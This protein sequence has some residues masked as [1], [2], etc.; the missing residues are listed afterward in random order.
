MQLGSNPKRKQCNSCPI[1]QK[2]H[3]LLPILPRLALPFT[4]D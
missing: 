3:R 1:L 4:R 2:T